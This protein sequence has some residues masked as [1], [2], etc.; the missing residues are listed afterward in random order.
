MDSLMVPGVKTWINT[1]ALKNAKRRAA[2]ESNQH[3]LCTA[4]LEAA[5]YSHSL[6]RLCRRGFEN[7]RS[8]E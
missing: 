5:T 2:A 8:L 4:A 3:R 7:D 1:E 6:T